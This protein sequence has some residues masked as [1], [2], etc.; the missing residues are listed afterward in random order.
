MN[1]TV[2]TKGGKR[3]IEGRAAQTVLIVSLLIA[4]VLTLLPVILTIFLSFKDQNDMTSSSIWSLPQNGW[5]FENYA[6]AFTGTMRYMFN[7]LAIVFISVF[8]TMLLSCYVAYL[9][10]RKEF[11]GKNVLF[12]LIILPMLVPSVVLLSPTFLTIIKLN[13]NGS[14][15]G[16]ILPYI[17]GNQIATIFL[18]R[19]FIGQQPADLYEAAAIDGGGVFRMFFSICLP[20][21]VPIMMV[22]G[23][24]I[25]AA[26]YNDYLFPQL[27]FLKADSKPLSTLMPML[28]QISDSAQG[29]EKYAVYLVSGIPLIITTIVSLKFFI[30]GEFAAGL[31]L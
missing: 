7:T 12:F 4:L 15:W 16:L 5:H 29:G 30:S 11:A 10:V 27:I 21:S 2:K 24:S 14:W 25:F 8:V 3:G 19:T 17:A 6:S 9:F 23:V 1:L 28:R 31:K 18:L 20:L 26:M 22:Q 13:L